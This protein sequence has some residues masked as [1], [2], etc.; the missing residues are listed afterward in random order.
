M[1]KN[2]DL[3]FEK[4]S[5][6]EKESIINILQYVWKDR[7]Y[8]LRKSLFEWKYELNPLIPCLFFIAKLNNKVVGYRGYVVNPI[9]S[10]K[11]NE[12][13]YVA[14]LADAVVHPDFR[15]FGIFKRLTEYSIMSLKN[16]YSI[17]IVLALSSNKFSTPGYIK[18]GWEKIIDKKPIFKLS[19]QGL[20]LNLINRDINYKNK[21]IKIINNTY[22]SFTNVVDCDL[23]KVSQLFNN[24]LTANKIS[25]IK[26]EDWL[27][28]K[29]SN[30]TKF[31]KFALCWEGEKLTSFLVLEKSKKYWSIVDYVFDD[32]NIFK[33]LIIKALKVYK[34]HILMSW[35]CTKKEEIIDLFYS[36]G[37]KHFQFTTK[38]LS[39]RLEPILVRS[40][41]PEQN[42]R[43]WNHNNFD[44]RDKESWQI[45][46][47][48]SDAS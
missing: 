19:M 30:P 24:N 18:L 2:L 46:L 41:E 9:I 14:C 33:M 43:V 4:Y 22:F 28:W 35:S 45:S 16:D 5:L 23:S 8:N 15:G 12:L 48:E 21:D 3:V 39:K 11:S 36:I 10:S 29:F 40:T 25:V 6:D 7:D 17:N 32:I 31:Y 20:F 26:T 27:K 42:S 34:P 37:F 13:S 38:I 47:I 44:I 1:S